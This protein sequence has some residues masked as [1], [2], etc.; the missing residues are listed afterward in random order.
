MCAGNGIM[1][2]QVLAGRGSMEAVHGALLTDCVR[3]G[4]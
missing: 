3:G 2:G 4:S 1:E